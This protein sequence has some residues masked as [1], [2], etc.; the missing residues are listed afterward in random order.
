MCVCVLLLYTFFF[1]LGLFHFLYFFTCDSECEG[2]VYYAIFVVVVVVV[3][4]GGGGGGEDCSGD[5][6]NI[7][8]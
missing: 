1:C 2:D 8:W 5:N 3:V 7:Q 6:V 4:G